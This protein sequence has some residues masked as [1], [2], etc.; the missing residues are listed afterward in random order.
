MLFHLALFLPH[1]TVVQLIGSDTSVLILFTKR[2]GMTFYHIRRRI[3]C[4]QFLSCTFVRISCV[5][6]FIVL[7]PLLSCYLTVFTCSVVSH[8]LLCLFIHFSFHGIF[9]QYEC[10]AIPLTHVSRHLALA[11]H[12]A[13]CYWFRAATLQP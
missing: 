6:D 10:A 4:R 3:F 9:S 8:L 1:S 2:N 12:S 7:V 5:V 11:T 13:A